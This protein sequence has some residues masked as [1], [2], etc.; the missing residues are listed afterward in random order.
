MSADNK[1]SVNYNKK[2]GN[3]LGF[4]FFETLLKYFGL[5]SAYFFLYFIAVY[6]LVFDKDAVLKSSNY[7]QLRFPNA[8]L[9][10]RYYHAYMLFVSQ[11][12][13]LI[14]RHIYTAKPELFNITTNGNDELFK[15]INDSDKGIIILTSHF[16]NWLI[17]LETLKKFGNR[18][19]N[20]LI[21]SDS[22][23]AIQKLFR[24]DMKKRIN[25]IASESFLGGSVEILNALDKG[26]IVTLTGDRH[27]GGKTVGIEF[28]GK[29]AYFPFS[30]FV[31]AS[32]R[33]CPVLFLNTVKTGRKNY[34]IFINKHVWPDVKK[35]KDS[36]ENQ[37]K[38]YVKEFAEEL[39]RI[40]K[41]YPYQ[42]FLFNNVWKS[43]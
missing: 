1:N 40:S 19:T 43:E 9:F 35:Q 23:Q 6:Y 4:W 39:E 2:R 22:N 42:C 16:G 8:G 18:Q 10:K 31:F 20:I 17:G 37:L 25:F 3:K 24:E 38:S 14:D 29:T 36:K 26:D 28:F 32:A 15:Y 11:G 7:I 13:Q 33:K 21:R 34:E 27:Y 30:A 12:Q 41:K 5:S